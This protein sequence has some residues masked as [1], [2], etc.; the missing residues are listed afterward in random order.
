M[1]DKAIL[2]Y[3]CIWSHGSQLVLSFVGCL[4]PENTGW[5]GQPTLFF[6]RR[7]NPPLFLQFSARSPTSVP[8]L[9]LMVETKHPHPHWSGAGRPSQGVAT[10]GSC[11]QVPLENGNCVRFDVCR[12]DGSPGWIDPE[13]PFLQSLLHFFFVSVFHLDRNISVLKALR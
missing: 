12:Q 9:R 1:S 3:I 10:P 5:S 11:Q 7:Y 4:V 8:K 2:C 13:W 6:L